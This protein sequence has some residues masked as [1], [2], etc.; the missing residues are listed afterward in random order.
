MS[1]L[2]PALASVK[3][4]GRTRPKQVGGAWCSETEFL[5]SKRS[6][7]STLTP[8]RLPELWLDLPVSW[9]KTSE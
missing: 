5:E 1:D 6:E 2:M 9:E 3:A 8:Y 7:S 4:C